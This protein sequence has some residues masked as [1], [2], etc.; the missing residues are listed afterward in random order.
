MSHSA[1]LEY[2]FP[3]THSTNAISVA[4]YVLFI[5]SSPDTPLEPV[6][7]TG[8]QLAACFYALSIVLG[9]LYCG[10]HG[11]FDVLIGSTLGALLSLI[12][13]KLGDDF[14]NI[15]Y[16]SSIKSPLT[17]ALVILITVRIHPEPADDCPCFDDS[18]AFAG[19]VIGIY[20]GSWRF[21]RNNAAWDSQGFATVPFDFEFLGILKSIARVLLGIAM[22]IVWKEATKPAMLKTLPYVLRVVEKT[23]L[24]H[25][26]RFFIPASY[27]QSCYCAVTS[28]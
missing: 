28:H 25:A 20:L 22:I 14:D 9:R 5:L 23:G 13:Y 3:S 19:V 10:M 2:G 12:Q 4:V 8:L 26:R 21:A 1:A 7:R 11:F 6:W 27:D 15:I 16:S 17:V 24:S 18:V